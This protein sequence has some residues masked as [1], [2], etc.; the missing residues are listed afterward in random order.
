MMTLEIY[1]KI[2]DRDPEEELD[3]CEE[4]FYQLKEFVEVAAKRGM[5]LIIAIT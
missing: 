3:Y 2:W 4:Y 1:P 5:G